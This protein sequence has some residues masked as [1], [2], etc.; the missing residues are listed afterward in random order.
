[1][2]DQHRDGMNAIFINLA[3]RS[4]LLVEQQLQLLH[5]MQREERDPA[6]LAGLFRVD[7]LASR[8]R[9]NDENLL[10]L[11]GGQPRRRAGAG[12]SLDDLVLAALSEVEQY[13]RLRPEFDVSGL[14]S[15]HATADLVHLLAE[16]VENA[17]AFSPPDS[18]VRILSTK[19]GGDAVI[20]IAD[21]GIGLSPGALAEANEMLEF[22]PELDLASSERMGLVVVSH[23]A[24]RHRVRVSLR[25][26]HIGTT[27]TVRIPGELWRTKGAA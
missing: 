23:L 14:V 21:E 19:D 22:P 8:L 20:E 18:P 15:G 6:R 5:E 3:R 26:S 11:A 12:L 7:H 4:Q 1:M 9:R 13:H 2:I 24:A 25:S 10:V 16:L 27:A 17:I